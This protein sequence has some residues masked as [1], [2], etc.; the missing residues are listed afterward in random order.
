MKSIG[1]DYGERRIGIAVSDPDGKIAFPRGIIIHKSIN[2]TIRKIINTIKAE[3][4]ENIIVGLPVGLDGRQTKQT[5]IVK[6]FVAQ[7]AKQTDMPIVLENEMFTTRIPAE[8][9]IAKDHI[10]ASSAALLL[11]SYLDKRN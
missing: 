2:A 9:G 4:I 5:A 1:I 8:T 11:Q 7:L 10:D 3:H 6:S